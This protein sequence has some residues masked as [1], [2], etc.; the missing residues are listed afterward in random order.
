MHESARRAPPPKPVNIAGKYVIQQIIARRNRGKHLAHR[1]RRGVLVTRAGGR[2][3]HNM[4]GFG[5]FGRHHAC[6]RE[7]SSSTPCSTAFCGTSLE[8]FTFPISLRQTNW[9]PPLS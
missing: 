1:L 2:S 6:E 5:S 3:S 7:R 8:I 4:F 9:A